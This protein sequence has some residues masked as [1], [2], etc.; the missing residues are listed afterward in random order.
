MM[1]KMELHETDFYVFSW[2]LPLSYR[3]PTLKTKTQ[4]SQSCATLTE[5]L[6]TAACLLLLRY[7]CRLLLTSVGKAGKI[8]LH[9]TVTEQ[10]FLCRASARRLL[11]NNNAYSLV[12]L[13]KLEFFFTNLHEFWQISTHIKVLFKK[14]TIVI[15]WGSSLQCLTM[16]TFLPEKYLNVAF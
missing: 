1:E 8:R 15:S 9:L 7:C 13:L 16:H 10:L 11:S 12:C 3:K 5:N 4:G 2:A 14:S 6:S